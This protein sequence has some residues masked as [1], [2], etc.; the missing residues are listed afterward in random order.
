M[1]SCHA[2]LQT[3][4]KYKGHAAS[5]TLAAIDHIYCSPGAARN[6][7]PAD[8]S[9]TRDLETYFLKEVRRAILL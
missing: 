5:K 9:L 1:A 3:I 6:V 4:N 2:A 8:V 7:D